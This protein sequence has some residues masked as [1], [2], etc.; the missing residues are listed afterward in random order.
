MEPRLYIWTCPMVFWKTTHQILTFWDVSISFLS[1]YH[2]CEWL[3]SPVIPENQ[4]DKTFLPAVHSPGLEDPLLGTEFTHSASQPWLTPLTAHWSPDPM[5][6]ANRLL[7]LSWG[8]LCLLGI[9]CS[10][11]VFAVIDTFNLTI[12]TPQWSPFH[13]FLLVICSCVNGAPLSCT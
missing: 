13:S 4:R 5:S 3:A 11:E 7:V 9:K 2:F 6:E 10:A 1:L 12:V 8:G